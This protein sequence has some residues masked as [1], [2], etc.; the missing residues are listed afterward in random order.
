M[1]FGSLACAIITGFVVVPPTDDVLNTSA[2]AVAVATEQS[3]GIMTFCLWLTL[4]LHCVNTIAGIIN[5][6]GKERKVCFANLLLV[7]GVA[8]IGLL[9]FMQ[10]AFFYAQRE[11]CM[12]SAEGEYFWLYGQI[13]MLYLGFT[14]ILCYVFRGFC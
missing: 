14:F 11:R 6:L 1:V 3:C 10:V 5:L 7:F 4:I 12:T 9:V 8:E 2:V 13:L